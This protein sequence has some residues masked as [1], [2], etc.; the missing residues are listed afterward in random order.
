MPFLKISHLKVIKIFSCFLLKALSFY[1][2]HLSLR[3]IR[4]WFL[5]MVWRKIRD[6]F[7]THGAPINPLYWK[8]S[9]FPAVFRWSLCCKPGGPGSG[10]SNLFHCSSCLSLHPLHAVLRAHTQNIQRILIEKDRQ[11]NENG[12]MNS[13]GIPVHSNS[14]VVIM[15]LM[16]IYWVP[17][18]HQNITFMYVCISLS[19]FTYVFHCPC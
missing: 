16:C 10:F 18:M 9:P 4:Y 7:F 8:S 12:L 3:S 1:L 13:T 6:S 11:P 17:A 5:C 2:L 14:L 15:D 19:M